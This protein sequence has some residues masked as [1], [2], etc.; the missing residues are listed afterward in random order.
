MNSYNDPNA[1]AAG[2]QTQQQQQPQ[3]QQA[4]TP[5]A[6]ANGNQEA[7]VRSHSFCILLTK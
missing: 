3:Q 5:P 6:N 4:T 2:Q 1:T 7:L